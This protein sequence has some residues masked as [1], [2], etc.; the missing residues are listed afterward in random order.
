MR[1]RMRSSEKNEKNEKN[2]KPKN[3][4]NAKKTKTQK[5]R[6]DFWLE[7]KKSRALWRLNSKK[8]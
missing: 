1:I 8:N 3:E 6:Y 2:E 4:Q 7:L 5:K